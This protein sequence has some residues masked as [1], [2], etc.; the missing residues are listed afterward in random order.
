MYSPLS[1]ACFLVSRTC[2]SYTTEVLGYVFAFI[3]S[4]FLAQRPVIV[5][6]TEV[7]GY[8]L[9]FSLFFGLKDLSQLYLR[10]Y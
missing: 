3:C 7:L 10:R 2:H 1:V 6:S 9:V 8:V 5:T 4:L